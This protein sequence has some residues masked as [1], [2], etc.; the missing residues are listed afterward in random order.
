MDG[1]RLEITLSEELLKRVD[2]VVEVLGFGSREE[3][4]LAAVRRLLDRYR[5]IVNS[6]P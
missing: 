5:F 6:P 3:F 2:E 1:E 4:V